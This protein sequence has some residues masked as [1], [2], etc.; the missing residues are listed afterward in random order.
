MGRNL[1]KRIMKVVKI[2]PRNKLPRNQRDY[3]DYKA[4][5]FKNLSRGDIVSIEFRKKKISGIVWDI[6]DKDEEKRSF[7]HLFFDWGDDQDTS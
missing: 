1:K 5:D 7:F 2:V 3:F 6:R 4:D